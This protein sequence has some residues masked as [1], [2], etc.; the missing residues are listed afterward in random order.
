MSNDVCW[1]RRDFLAVSFGRDFVVGERR[2]YG[3][4]PESAS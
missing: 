4:V 3:V 1:T 2:R